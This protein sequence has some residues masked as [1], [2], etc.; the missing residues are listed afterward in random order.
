MG[1]LVQWLDCMHHF[2]EVPLRQF[3]FHLDGATAGPAAV[4]GNIGKAL[5]KCNELSVV[6]F[7]ARKNLPNGLQNV[8][9]IDISKD[10]QYLYNICKSKEVGGVTENLAKKE[11]SP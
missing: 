3:I 5:E 10:Q 11:P 1:C 7:E 2:N 9:D 8:Y 6:K 4:S